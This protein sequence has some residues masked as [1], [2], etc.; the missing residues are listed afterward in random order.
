MVDYG[1]GVKGGVVTMGG[2]GTDRRCLR[3]GLCLLY[4][5]DC[6]SGQLR[7]VLPLLHCVVAKVGEDERARM[8][9]R[10]VKFK[11]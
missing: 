11:V 5:S 9:F 10:G 7:D 3:H 8:V 1:P 6:A 2:V 4:V